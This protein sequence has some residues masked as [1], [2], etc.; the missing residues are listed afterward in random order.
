MGAVGEASAQ[1]LAEHFEPSCTPGRGC[2]LLPTWVSALLATAH[3]LPISA[4]QYPSLV[5]SETEQGREPGSRS[6][7]PSWALAVGQTP[8]RGNGRALRHWVKDSA[9]EP[10]QVPPQLAG[11]HRSSTESAATCHRVGVAH[12]SF[13]QASLH[14][15]EGR[16]RVSALPP[17]LV[18]GKASNP[19]GPF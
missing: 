16:R 19:Q 3:G 2:G 7:V 18:A 14:R 12:A 17:L 1:P 6:L 9:K 10:A 15:C 11:L 13:T 5:P 8:G 4:Y